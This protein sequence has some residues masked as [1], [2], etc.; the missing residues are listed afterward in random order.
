MPGTGALPGPRG[1]AATAPPRPAA[2]APPDGCRGGREPRKGP[3]AAQQPRWDDPAVLDDVIAQLRGRPPLVTAASCD[4][5]QRELAAAARGDAVVVQAGDCAEPFAD[6]V[7]E[8]VAAKADLLALLADRV[9]LST[10]LPTVR[11]GRFAGQYAK[12]RSQDTEVLADGTV[13]PVYRGD[14]VNRPDPLPEAR[15][16]DARRLLAAYD[17]SARALAEILP[18]DVLAPLDAGSG[19]YCMTYASHEALLL[20][21]EEALV[22]PHRGGGAYGSSG[23]LLWIGER[24]RDPA[25]AHVAF[26]ERITN[27]VAV[28]IGPTAG[29]AEVAAL[30]ARLTV[31]HPPG[32]LCLVIR[33]GADRAG[34]ELPRLLREMGPAARHALWLCDPMHG[35][36]RLNDHGQKTRLLADVVK[37][38]RTFCS[39]LGEAG[40]PVGG[41]HLETTPDPVVECVDDAADLRLRLDHYTSTCDPRL[42]PG[43]AVAVVD[44]ALE[45][46]LAPA[47]RP[48]RVPTGPAGTR[49][50]SLSG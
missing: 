38:V 21:Y 5:L 1:S 11:V 44:A 22:R 26:A 14:A 39:V 29:G 36:T 3:P 8:R 50:A 37:E 41:L 12:P 6:S 49:Q 20:D 34:F 2:T 28:K 33:M 30:V 15:A 24:T 10:G 43:Q 40:L 13:L 9:E 48:P 19:P 42:N 4:A 25:G 35:N 16:C 17:H 27:P 23:H 7:P 32:R 47:Y 31:G 18:A 46:G 45:A